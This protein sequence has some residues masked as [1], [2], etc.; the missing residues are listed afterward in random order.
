MI[1]STLICVSIVKRTLVEIIKAA[2]TLLKEPVDLLELRLDYLKPLPELEQVLK[3]LDVKKPKIITFRPRS[4]G[5]E[6]DLDDESRINIFKE[7]I[8][9]RVEYVDIEYSTLKNKEVLKEAENYNV[10]TILS[11]HILDETPSFKE[12]K[13][14]LNNMMVLK[15][16][17]IKISTM[18]M[19]KDD[20]I[21][22]SKLISYANKKNTPIVVTGM[23]E[24]GKIT[25]ILNPI[26]GSK[27]TYCSM[28]G[29]PAAPGQLDYN[30]TITMLKELF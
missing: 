1:G 15:P 21:T 19:D 30:K 11:K 2:N 22:L 28:P 8:K 13:T 10:K 29:E 23:G 24:L 7:F 17:F 25:R 26:M 18:I 12:L 14:L 3:L 6:S 16:S 20:V 4:E 5:G 27:I 9:K